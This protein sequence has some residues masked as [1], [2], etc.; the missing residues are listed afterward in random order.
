MG[1]APAPAVFPLAAPIYVGA[2]VLGTALL[3][4]AA[5]FYA[6]EHGGRGVWLLVIA[7]L[8]AVP[9]SEFTLQSFNGC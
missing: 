6:N 4:A 7:L 9:A 8:G 2:I 3:L 5:L 1:E